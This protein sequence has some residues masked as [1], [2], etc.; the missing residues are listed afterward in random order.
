MDVPPLR[1][2]GKCSHDRDGDFVNTPNIDKLMEQAELPH[3]WGEN[4]A[5]ERLKELFTTHGSAMV[6][7]LKVVARSGHHAG[8]EW[9]S[10]LPQCTCGVARVAQLLTQLDQE[11]HVRSEVD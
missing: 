4:A 5:D 10:Q 8:C 6:A 11:A 9:Y 1:K 3:V 7:A 2:H